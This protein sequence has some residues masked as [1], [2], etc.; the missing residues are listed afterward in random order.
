MKI[1][2]YVLM[3]GIIGLMIFNSLK[4]DF[5]ALFEGE[6]KVAVAL[7]LAG[8]CALVLLVILLLSKRIEKLQKNA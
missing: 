7:I 5:D 4:L 6:S 3:A 1:L 8:L 2:I